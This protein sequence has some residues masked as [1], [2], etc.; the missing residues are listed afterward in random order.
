MKDDP[1]IIV[2]RA[3]CKNIDETDGRQ[4]VGFKPSNS[5]D[6]DV[7]AEGTFWI[8]AIVYPF[9]Q[10]T[11]MAPPE[12]LQGPRPMMAMRCRVRWAD[13]KDIFFHH[14]TFYWQGMLN[15]Y[16]GSSNILTKY[17]VP[18]INFRGA[19]GHYLVI[20]DLNCHTA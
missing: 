3:L 17:E 15:L 4:S 8:C 6:F 1:E 10:R 16:T 13:R 19:T 9:I 2:P 12:E 18:R 5:S 11:Y 7:K 14:C 20:L